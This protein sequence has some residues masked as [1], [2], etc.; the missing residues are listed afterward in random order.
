MYEA[1]KVPKRPVEVPCDVTQHLVAYRTAVGTR[2]NSSGCVHILDNTLAAALH[3]YTIFAGL[4]VR[5]VQK[6]Y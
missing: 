1:W 4:V 2:T 6:L 5:S 3:A